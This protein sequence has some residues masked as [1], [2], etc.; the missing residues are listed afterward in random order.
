MRTTA[1]PSTIVV[2]GARTGTA[3]RAT[4][5]TANPV[6]RKIGRYSVSENCGTSVSYSKTTAIAL[7]NN[8][9]DAAQRIT[10][11]R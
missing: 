7:P 4:Q 9:I 3:A 1:Y 10:R 5:A 8:R 2:T 6:A 11:W